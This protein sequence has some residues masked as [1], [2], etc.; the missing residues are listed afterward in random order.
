MHRLLLYEYVM[1]LNNSRPLDL[2]YL[3][4]MLLSL[5]WVRILIYNFK[6]MLFKS[7][8]TTVITIFIR[9]GW[10]KLH[11]RW[12]GIGRFFRQSGTCDWIFS[13]HTHSLYHLQR[14]EKRDFVQY[15]FGPDRTIFHEMSITDI[16]RYQLM[17]CSM[18]MGC[19][20]DMD[21]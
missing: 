1:W 2:T 6:I 3:Y 11:S 7:A 19:C 12:G 13:S 20:K 17:R 14:V 18:C 16:K 15:N 9:G 5:C 8:T 10:P 4:Q 21:T